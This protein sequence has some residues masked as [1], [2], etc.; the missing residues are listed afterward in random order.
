MVLFSSCPLAAPCP[1]V[2]SNVH[3]KGTTKKGICCAV[4]VRNA[5]VARVCRLRKQTGS[6]RLYQGTQQQQVFGIRVTAA[7]RE[8]PPTFRGTL[9]VVP[10]YP[11]DKRFSSSLRGRADVVPIASSQ[12]PLERHAL[13]VFCRVTITD[14]DVGD[15][16]T[17]ARGERVHKGWQRMR[18]VRPA[19]FYR[20]KYY[21][22]NTKRHC[23]GEKNSK[24]V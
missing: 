4:I 10:T 24:D 1:V 3:R 22:A 9:M 12:H 17:C 7:A 21:C 14:R 19:L 23:F 16:D 2:V 11:V 13:A 20:G 5:H 8:L 6:N 18:I 15:L